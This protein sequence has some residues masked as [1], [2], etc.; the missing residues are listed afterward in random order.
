MNASRDP[1]MGRRM[2]ATERVLARLVES[3]EWEIDAEG[4]IWRTSIRNGMRSG[5]SRLVPVQRRRVEKKVRHGYLIVRAMLDGKR[6]HGSAHRLVWH[7]LRGP[8]PDG[9]EINH[10]NGVKDDNR[11]ENLEPCT[12]SENQ[13]HAYRTGLKDQRGERSPAAKL[14]DRQVAE[15][16]ERY[17]AGGFTMAQLGVLYSVSTQHIWSLIRGRL[18]APVVSSDLRANQRHDKG[19]PERVGVH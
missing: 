11:P 14:S 12:S 4:R 9:L 16:R 5:E 15:I 6:V 7:C 19:G 18:R 2:L 17:A 8:I 1:R 10:R 3:G 13:R